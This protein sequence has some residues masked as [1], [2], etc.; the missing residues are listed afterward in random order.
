MSADVFELTNQVLSLPVADR[1]R[2]AQKLWESLPETDAAERPEGEARALELA[3]R[4]DAEMASGK[5][6]G[7]PHDQVMQNARRSIGCE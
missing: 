1:V 2:L 6:Q 3:R 5:V 7:I 4:R